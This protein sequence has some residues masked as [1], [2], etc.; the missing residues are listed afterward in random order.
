[1]RLAIFLLLF[2]PSLNSVTQEE[3]GK[4]YFETLPQLTIMSDE[5]IIFCFTYSNNPFN[6]SNNKSLTESKKTIKRL[7]YTVKL[8]CLYDHV[9]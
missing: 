3:L 5:F 6:E 2:Y 7:T 1:M 9:R 8:V 4:Q